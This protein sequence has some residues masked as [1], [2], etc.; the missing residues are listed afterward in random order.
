MSDA[1]S[2]A[3]TAAA[4]ARR[5]VAIIAHVDHGKTT[6]VDALLAQSGAFRANERVA[7]R[8]LDNIALERERG[9]TIM[10]KN[11]AVRYGGVLVNIVDTPGHADFGGEVERTLAMVDGVLLLVDASEGP[12]PQTRYVLRKALERRLPPIVVI[13]KIDRQDARPSEVLNEVYDLFIDLDASEDQ[14]GFPVLYT[15]A[16]AGTAASGPSAP[17][18]D[19]R[20]LF[21]AIVAHVPPPAGDPGAPLQMLVANLD[22]SDFVGRIAICRVFNGRVRLGDTVAVSK[23]DGSLAVTRVTQLLAFDGLKRISVD[24]AAAGDIV[25][26][27]GIADITIGETITD[28]ER[29]DPLPPLA[30]DEPTVSMVFGVNTSPMAGREGTFVTSRQIRDRLERELL[31]NV[32][33]RLEGTSSPEQVRVIGRGELQ[34][35][36]LIEMMRREGYEL[37]VSRPDIVTRQAQGQTLE[38]VETL[39]IDVPEEY[40]GVVIAQ[41][42]VRRGTMTRLVNHGSGRVR[43]E[44]EIPTRGLIGFRAQFLTD[45]RG[46]GIMN[47]L[48]HGW[49][50]WV[51]PIPAR[52]TGALVADRAGVSTAYAI[53]NLQERGEIFIEPGTPVYEGLIVG[54]NARAND[55][56]VNVTKEKKQTNMRASTAD[57]AIRLVPPRLPGLE[58]ALAFINDDELV[59]V[60]P[61]SIRLRKRILAANMRPKSR[62]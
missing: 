4:P 36:I 15:N 24:E 33:I 53:Y 6:L 57:E 44:F 50:P 51:G 10:A 58:P 1:R 49:R 59:E 32:S 7:E 38:P 20:P 48:F 55:L 39:V 47:H 60:T 14:L 11:T 30:V 3:P 34:L 42:G 8:A 18:T 35:S 40:Q 37:Q 29:P 28:A 41:V 61:K 45:T 19:L 16:R 22:S 25:C 9:I 12:L 13:N 26:V 62:A 23:A 46:T 5:N 2:P 27:A 52:T 54:E 31:G 43:I 21:D 56:D 17:G